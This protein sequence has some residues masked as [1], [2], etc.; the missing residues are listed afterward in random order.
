[1]KKRSSGLVVIVLYKA[2]TAVLLVIISIFLL[3]ATKKQPQL[4][5]LED[6]LTLAGK[7]SMIFWVIE[8]ILNFNPKTLQ[9]S[10]IVAGVYAAV[11]VIEAAGLW[12]QKNWARWLTV[13][14]VAIGVLPEILELIKGFSLLKLMVLI[15]NLGVLIYLLREKK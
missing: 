9:V 11:S 4:L 14:L 5:Q 6:S 7:R 3:L 10:G 13:G 8:K 1:M 12:Q 15:A 2:I